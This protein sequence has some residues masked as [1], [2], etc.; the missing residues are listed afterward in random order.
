ME[1]PETRLDRIGKPIR[2]ALAAETDPAAD[3]RAARAGFL[4]QV[5]ARNARPTRPT[6]SARGSA[7]R[8]RLPLLAAASAAGAIGL[9]IWTSIPI[10]FQVGAAGAPGRLGDLIE[11]REEHG[12]P[13]R[14]SEGSTIGLRRGGGVRVLS[15]NAK[16][17]RVLVE[18]GTVDVV[19]ARPPRSKAAW[20]F[21]AG[22]YRVAVTGTQFQMNYRPQDQ[23]LDLAT[24]EGQ[25][26]VSGACL[27]TPRPVSAGDHFSSS[28]LRKEPSGARVASLSELA[29]DPPSQRSAAAPAPASSRAEPHWRDLLATG[30]LAEGLRAAERANFYRVCQIATAR[31]LLALADAA[32]LFGRAA[33]AVTALRVL[34]QRYPSSP[35]ASTAAFTLGRIAFEQQRDY[36]EAVRWFATYLREQ[37]NGPLFGDSVGRVMEARLRSGDIQRARVDAEQYLR[38]FPEGPYASEARGIL[39]R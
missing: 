26:V 2:E 14:F 6:W 19:I 30:R 16:G 10:S 25:V 27:K 36:D 13:L 33:R 23:T 8:W 31:E 5:V 18:N 21:E 17:A 28:C 32:R 39:A 34:R 12:T 15:A 20:T 3:I 37:P 22:P 9:W 38:R 4:E 24:R 11:G 7:W 1:H 35:D 29:A